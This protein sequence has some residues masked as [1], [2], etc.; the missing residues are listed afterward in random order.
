MMDLFR[1]AVIGIVG[2]VAAGTT[3]AVYDKLTTHSAIVRT[4]S[5]EELIGEI[6]SEL[7]RFANVPGPPLGL[8][9]AEVEITLAVDRE[10][11]TTAEGTFGVPV[12]DELSMSRSTS[13]VEQ[14]TSK[15]VVVLMP[16]KGSQI[17]SAGQPKIEFANL[18]GEVRR[19]IQSSMTSEPRLDAKSIEVS[20]GFVLTA[21][22]TD[23]IAVKVKVLGIGAEEDSSEKS[24]NTIVLKYENPRFATAKGETEPNPP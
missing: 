14:Q 15:V 18:L 22:R 17:M 11:G 24:G 12:F 6:K 8:D 23:K 3:A 1:I 4:M 16:P 20:L 13:N 2:L 21:K 9:L 5:I 7:R 19:Q 10:I